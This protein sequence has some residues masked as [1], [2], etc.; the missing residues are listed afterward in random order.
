[1]S[2][3]CLQR[4][5]LIV[6]TPTRHPATCT[7]SPPARTFTSGVSVRQAISC[8][9][10]ALPRENLHM[11]KLLSF[12]IGAVSVFVTVVVAGGLVSTQQAP[13]GGAAR[14]SRLDAPTTRCC[15][16]RCR[17]APRN[18]RPSTAS[19]CIATSSRRRRSRA[20]IATQGTRSSGAAS[21]APRRD[22]ESAE[23]LAGRFRDV[24]LSDVRIQPFDLAPQWMP[25]SWE[26]SVTAGGKTLK[27][28]S[29]QPNY[30]AV[31]DAGRRTRPRGACTSASAAKP[32][33]SARTCEARRCSYYTQVGLQLGTGL[34][35]AGQARRRQGRGRVSSRST[36][37]RAT[38]ATRAIPSN[39][40]APA[41][42]V[43][44]GDGF[45][46]A[47]HDSPRRRTQAPRVQ[48]RPRRE[49][50]AE[51]EDGAGLGHAAGRDRTRRSTSSRTATAGSTRRATT[52]AAWRR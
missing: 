52:P 23:W 47:R 24:G 39:T 3:I 30:A 32:T 43:G 44:S 26:V 5:R 48:R 10:R 13:G 15:A 12:V 16:G 27:L 28:E 17:R 29:A 36:C 45:A 4:D 50:G 38:C 2:S 31:R 51:P 22:A 37:C 6:V 46:V 41:F 7:A 1:M 8:L 33:T 21:S 14:E 49:D 42:T 20:G 9:N 11:R 19:G 18:T 25:Q 34:D 35:G 40:K